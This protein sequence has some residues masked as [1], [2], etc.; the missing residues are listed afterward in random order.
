MGIIKQ[1]W[2]P[3]LNK[4]TEF[5]NFI[6]LKYFLDIT[7]KDPCK[8]VEEVIAKQMD[9]RYNIQQNPKISKTIHLSALKIIKKFSISIRFAR[10][11]IRV[12]HAK[13]AKRKTSN[14]VCFAKAHKPF[15]FIALQNFK[16]KYP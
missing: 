10:H 16:V 1:I 5:G 7:G 3:R 14:V 6:K 4:Q 11:K 8:T 12:I 15:C 9:E 2:T 13:Q